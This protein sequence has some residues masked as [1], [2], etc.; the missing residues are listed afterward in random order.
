[1]FSLNFIFN[2]SFRVRLPQLPINDFFKIQMEVSDFLLKLFVSGMGMLRSVFNIEVGNYY[3]KYTFIVTLIKQEK[4]VF[5]LVI[6][7]I[8]EYSCVFTNCLRAA[9][10]PK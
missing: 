4:F 6:L 7:C 1:M 9:G 5:I 3:S 2:K 10:I 8:R